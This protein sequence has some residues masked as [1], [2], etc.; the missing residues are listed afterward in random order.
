MTIIITPNRPSNTAIVLQTRM[1]NEIPNS[2]SY[3][4]SLFETNQFPNYEI[5]HPYVKFRTPPNPVYNCHGLVFASKRTGIHR[6][7]VFQTILDDD[8]YTE[9]ER[10]N[11]LPGDVILYYNEDGDI[12]HS[13]IVISKPDEH[14]KIPQVVSKWGRYKEV[15]HYANDSPYTF[16]NVRYYRVTK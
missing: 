11:V 9:I 15:V 6:S 5:N 16:A 10:D 7:D 12:E 8:G 13:G 1:G 4:I 14:I 3:E 2:Q